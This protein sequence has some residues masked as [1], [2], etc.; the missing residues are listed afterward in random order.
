MRIYKAERNVHQDLRVLLYQTAEKQKDDPPVHKT[1]QQPRNHD[2]TANSFCQSKCV[3]FQLFERNEERD[4]LSSLYSRFY[5][6]PFVFP[7]NLTIPTHN[8]EGILPMR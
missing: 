6:R 7:N 8:T 1:K 3:P 5:T 4:K 2:W